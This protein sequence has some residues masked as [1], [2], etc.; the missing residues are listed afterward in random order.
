[1]LRRLGFALCLLTLVATTHAAT[2]GNSRV[3]LVI[4]NAAY[5]NVPLKNPVN[6]A[7]AVAAKLRKLGFQVLER[8]DLK[9]R[10]IG[11]VLSEFR[12][13]IVP[14]GAALFFYAGH[15]VQVDGVNYLP[16]VD[17]AI[18]S[19]EEVP[20]Q[21]VNLDQVMRA[22]E[23]GQS[24]VNLVFLDACR[25]NPYA[26]RTRSLGGGLAKVNAPSGT[27]ILYATRPGQIA[28]DGSGTHGL[29]T[30][31]LL[32]TL[33]QPGLSAEQV[34]KQVAA[35]VRKASNGQQE[36]WMEGMLE[37]D[38]Y[39]KPGTAPVSEQ[40]AAAT[41]Q[42]ERGLKPAVAE[43][44]PAAT[45]VSEA[46]PEAAYWA[47]VVSSGE[48][49]DYEAYLDAYPD[50]VHVEEANAWLAK[51]RGNRAARARILS[52]SPWGMSV[53]TGSAP[54]PAISPTAPR[55]IMVSP[56]SEPYARPQRPT[57]AQWH[58]MSQES[59]Q[60][61]HQQARPQMRQE[62]FIPRQPRPAEMPQYRPARPAF[63]KPPRERERMPR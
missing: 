51:E 54:A 1:M 62:L 50:G 31:N 11:Q 56:L 30:Q 22:M 7:R 9:Q 60:Q 36:P 44:V 3:A 23:L 15:G 39:F 42:E 12:S 52:E 49:V 40:A 28:A 21:S 35:A 57:P 13:R 33:D 8:H 59:K 37:G 18:G 53:L 5:Q 2:P 17:A 27:L 47:R 6:D 48:A 55:I 29:Y 26:G 16:A 34:Q 41:F 19:E 45:V 10:E 43:P 46:D 38:F 14:G 4:G 25:N 24:R 20:N 32:A 63:F 58:E 61:W